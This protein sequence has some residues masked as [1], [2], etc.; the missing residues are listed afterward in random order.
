[1]TPSLASFTDLCGL[2]IFTAGRRLWIG[3]TRFRF[4]RLWGLLTIGR[5]W[6]RSEHKVSHELP[7]VVGYG[8]SQSEKRP[9]D[10]LVSVRLMPNER[11]SRRA[12][13]V[14]TFEEMNV[15]RVAGPT[16]R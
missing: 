11:C 2:G 1:M 12:L 6:C 13:K 10:P 5:P 7:L 3:I 4:I 16:R 15:G 8:K 9:V 14:V